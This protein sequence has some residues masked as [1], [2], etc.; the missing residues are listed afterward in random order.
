MHGT[1]IRSVRERARVYS[2]SRAVVLFWAR[3]HSSYNI[4]DICC[5][6]CGQLYKQ[7]RRNR[8]SA[9]RN[10][11]C[12]PH[13]T[14]RGRAE[15]M[16]LWSSSCDG[17]LSGVRIAHCIVGSADH[18]N[19][20][21]RF[22]IHDPRNFDK[23]SRWLRELRAYGGVHDVFLSLDLRIWPKR[24][25]LAA[26]A[27]LAASPQGGASPPRVANETL[28]RML[29]SLKPA[30]FEPYAAPPVCSSEGEGRCLCQA[31]AYPGWWEQM[32][33]NAAC[34]R[35]VRR[36]EQ[37]TGVKYDYVTK[38][39][40]STKRQTLCTRISPSS[41]ALDPF[42]AAGLRSP[43]KLHA[44]THATHN[45]SLTRPACTRACLVLSRVFSRLPPLRLLACTQSDYNSEAPPSFETSAEMIV[46]PVREMQVSNASRAIYAK[47]WV[48]GLCYGQV[49]WFG[50]MP[51]SLAHSYFSVVPG[52]SCTWARS[53]R[54]RANAQSPSVRRICPTLN[55][56][57]LVHW[58]YDHG[59]GRFRSL[60]DV[61]QKS[62][63]RA[64]RRACGK[65]AAW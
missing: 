62:K 14:I 43:S 33:K 21:D 41:L 7:R 19:R 47:E 18:A 27:R 44:A 55:E 16:P 56:A 24:S 34:M 52:A 22:P 23:I 6:R 60:H 39:R 3:F 20:N 58:A 45:R 59:G 42:A 11:Y 61:S 13:D 25:D 4:F 37:E 49:D 9:A 65:S 29:D 57:T 38:Q 15:R 36:H 31:L 32:A 10:S 35:L 26:Q 5:E 1:V 50:L 53:T 46:Q 28:T 8:S 30:A 48:A 12:R 17:Y 63:G 54:D 40:V 64:L 51:R 2:R